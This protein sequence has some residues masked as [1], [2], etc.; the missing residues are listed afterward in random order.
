[1]ALFIKTEK[2]NLKSINLSKHQ[3]QSYIDRHVQ[4][5][6][7]LMASGL[8]ISSGYLVNSEKV[9]GGGGFLILQANSF[10]EAKILVEQDPLIVEDLVVW[11][12]QEWIPVAGNL[13]Q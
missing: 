10:H 11:Q 7:K 6:K 3:R 12:L 4:W 2:F 13:I 1:M 8:Q 5:I 9:A